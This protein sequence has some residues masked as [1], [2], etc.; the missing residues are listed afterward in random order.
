MLTANPGSQAKP[1]RNKTSV[2]AV[3]TSAEKLTQQGRMQVRGAQ[4]P[5]LLRHTHAAMH[6]PLMAA[7]TRS[8]LPCERG[9]GKTPKLKSPRNQVLG[10][11]L[12]RFTFVSSS[13]GT[14]RPSCKPSS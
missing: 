10:L 4:T 8:N 7:R 5:A 12:P 11:D 14:Q 13:S 2:N 9:D 3:A 6:L 1:Q